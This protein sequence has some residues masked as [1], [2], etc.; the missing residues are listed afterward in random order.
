MQSCHCSRRKRGWGRV[1]LTFLW[2]F[3]ELHELGMENGMSPK[4]L[5]ELVKKTLMDSE[6]FTNYTLL[7]QRKVSLNRESKHSHFVLF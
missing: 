6:I 7:K 4:P 2:S 5:L 1:G 3:K